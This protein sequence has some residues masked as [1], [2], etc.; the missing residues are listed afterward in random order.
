MFTVRMVSRSPNLRLRRY[1]VPRSQSDE[2]DPDL[3]FEVVYSVL[4]FEKV[5]DK[6]ED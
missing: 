1:Q 6:K 3:S 5:V 2:L 4:L